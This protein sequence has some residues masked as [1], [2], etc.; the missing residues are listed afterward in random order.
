MVMYA[1]QVSE[2]GATRQL[3]EHKRHPYTAGLMEAFP[4]IR[5]PRVALTGIPGNPPNLG[6]PQV[7]CRFAPRCPKCTERCKTDAPPEYL[8]EETSVRCFLYDDAEVPG[9]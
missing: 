6:R 4:S 7:G 9:D 5:G 1:G 3:F 8:V 2:V